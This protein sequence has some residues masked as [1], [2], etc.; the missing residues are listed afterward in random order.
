M[1]G[2]SLVVFDVD[3]TLLDSRNQIF[4]AM[5]EAFRMNSLAPPKRE[6]IAV[7]VGLSLPQAMEILAP[8]GPVP[9]LVAA[10]KQAYVAHLNARDRQASS[11]LFVGVDALLRDLRTA[12]EI[13]VGLA[14][15]KSR[16]GLNQFIE[17]HDLGWIATHQSA[18]EHPSKPHP[19][20]LYT[21]LEET[22]IKPENA[23]MIGDTTYDLEMARAAGTAAIGVTWGHHSAATL[24]DLSDVMVSSVADLYP[25]IL[26][27]M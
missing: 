8:D 10:Y 19:S 17:R 22:G 11:Q 20:M 24:R 7:I 5:E 21:A 9:A 2:R 3:G 25:A 13:L 14:T 12:P 15:G 27:L 18:D 1:S 26:R 6:D 16:R 23:V 4:T